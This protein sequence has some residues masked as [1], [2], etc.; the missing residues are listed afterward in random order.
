MHF[1]VPLKPAARLVHFF[2]LNL[3]ALDCVYLCYFRQHN[4]LPLHLVVLRH[5]KGLQQFLM[6]SDGGDVNRRELFISGV[7]TAKSWEEDQC[8]SLQH[9]ASRLR[10]GRV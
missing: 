2:L 4:E 5:V 3:N 1:L 10:P 6:Y 8:P 9:F 7:N